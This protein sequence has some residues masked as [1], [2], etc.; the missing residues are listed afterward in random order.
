MYL[1]TLTFKDNFYLSHFG[2]DPQCR[3]KDFYSDE[4]DRHQTARYTITHV[5]RKDDIVMNI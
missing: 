1:G 5:E 3:Q 4:K 2:F